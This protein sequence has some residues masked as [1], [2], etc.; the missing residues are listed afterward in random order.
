MSK[1][2]PD[3]L[4]ADFFSTP[5][6]AVAPDTLPAD[7]FSKAAA[8]VVDTSTTASPAPTG[9]L[10]SMKTM[11]QNDPMVNVLA[12]AAKDVGSTAYEI[13]K[14]TQHQNPLTPALIKMPEEKPEW[15]KPEGIAQNAGAA[16]STMAQFAAP[17]AMA[18]KVPATAVMGLT[19]RAALEGMM[20]GGVSKARGATNPEALTTALTTGGITG[21]M[22]LAAKAA[23]ALGER[24]ELALL[25]PLKADLADVKGPP[26]LAPQTMIKNLYKYDLGGTLPQSYEKAQALTKDLGNQ[27]RTALGS[28]PKAEVDLMNVLSDT[29]QE[30]KVNQAGNFGTNAN[31]G[32]AVNK[33]LDEIQ[34][35]TQSGKVNL[36]DAQ[37]VK[38]ALGFIGSWQNGLRD[39]DSTA[40]ETVANAMYSKLKTAIEKAS[41]QSQTVQDINRQFSE[42]I[43]IKNALIRRIPVAARQ[44]VIGLKQAIGLVAGGPSGLALSA[45][46]KLLKSGS[47]ADALVQAG[48]NPIGTAAKVAPL[49]G[50]AA[51]RLRS[52]MNPQP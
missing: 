23:P 33:M 30:L 16:L 22:G 2:A 32:K 18:A 29:A 9:F 14:R 13:F 42:I 27:L 45:A 46:D 6:S 3:T 49:V 40:T 38:Q 25:K 52:R 28:N 41:G 43:P 5:K 37:D 24:I 1:V 7:F 10:D 47:V 34:M 11:I 44:D 8:P 21:L 12:G 36:A 4:P 39:A 20:A 48:G 19:A 26:E 51:D 50:T 35:I 15:L 31:V 17:G